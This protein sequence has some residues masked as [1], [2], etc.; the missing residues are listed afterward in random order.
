MTIS[1]EC[2]R[3]FNDVRGNNVLLTQYYA[4]LD[5]V[6][7]SMLTHEIGFGGRPIEA[8]ST[9]VVIQ[10]QVM[11]CTDRTIYTGSEEEIRPLLQALALCHRVHPTVQEMASMVIEQTGGV[12]ILVVNAGPMLIG[13]I[14]LA[15]VYALVMGLPEELVNQISIEN[16]RPVA[17]LLRE[18]HTLEEVRSLLN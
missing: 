17:E 9:R 12:P 16:V 11:N 5:R 4:H 14:I 18:G 8:S 15:R 6:M 2:Y 10:T 13:R 7:E 1:V 3:D